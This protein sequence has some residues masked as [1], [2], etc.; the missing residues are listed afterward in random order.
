MC[1]TWNRNIFIK[2]IEGGINDSQTNCNINHI[3][4]ALRHKQHLV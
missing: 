1:D 4:M 3:S 2:E